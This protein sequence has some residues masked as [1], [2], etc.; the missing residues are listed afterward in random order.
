MSFYILGK[1]K[2][3]TD[4]RQLR[5]P[6]KSQAIAE[7]DAMTFRLDG[8]EDVTVVEKTVRRPSRARS[9]TLRSLRRR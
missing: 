3:Q 9:R 6:Y 2:G 7:H 1:R 8:F 5:G 4:E